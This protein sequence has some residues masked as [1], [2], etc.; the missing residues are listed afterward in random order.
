METFNAENNWKM[1]VKL[2]KSNK[3]FTFSGGEIYKPGKQRNAKTTQF[4]KKFKRTLLNLTI[5]F[6][7]I[8]YSF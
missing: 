3:I 1:Y 4:V 8:Y 7:I 6:Y 5:C 2:I